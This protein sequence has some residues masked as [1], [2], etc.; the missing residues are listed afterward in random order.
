MSGYGK[1]KHR[2][3]IMEFSAEMI[4]SFIGGEIIGDKN[5]TVNNLAKIEEGKKGDL[6]FLSN[7]KYEHY[8]YT[9]SSSII[10]VAKKFVPQEEVK[11]TMIKVE[12]PYKSF[13]D[14]LNLYI[15]NLP[16]PEGISEKSS[17]D[18]GAEIGE[19][20]YV[21][22]F[23]VIEKGVKIGN[24]CKIYPQ[25]YIGQNVKIGDNVTLRSGVKI[26]N[27]CVLGS[28]II[29]HSGVVIGADG[30]GF[31]PTGDTY[32]KIPQIGNVI[33]EDDIEIGANS[34]IDRATMGSTI[35]RKG[36]KIDNLCHVAHNVEIGQNT[37][38]AA[39][40]GIA[41]SSKMGANCMVAGQVGVAGHLVVADRSILAS[42]TGVSGSIKTPG[43]T[44]MGYPVMEANQFKRMFI[45]Q[46]TLPEMRAKL[47]AME[48]EV[49]QL[50]ETIEKTK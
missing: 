8:I 29:L 39:Q 16:Q 11:A 7:P 40:F 48:K 2:I 5:V 49:A 18:A 33:L 15:A 25:V 47:L 1:H 44:H 17:V 26:Y 9:S 50:K 10:I 4:A 21:G 27:D 20:A 31:A 23:T 12:D 35:I 28:N 38:L 36:V 24:N 13:A 30:F 41:G 14:I 34:T 22:D 43:G 3:K 19:K 32:Q 46:K 45:T 42:K 6:S 37:V